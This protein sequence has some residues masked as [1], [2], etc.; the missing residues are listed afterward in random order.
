MVRPVP[1]PHQPP[2]YAAHPVV[3]QSDYRIERPPMHHMAPHHAVPYG[4]AAGLPPQVRPQEPVGE[5]AWERGL[6][7]AK[8][9]MRKATKRK[10]QDIDFE[11]KKMNLSLTQDE[12]EKDNYYTRGSPES[13]S[14]GVRPPVAAAPYEFNAPPVTAKFT[15]PGPAPFEEDAFGRT[16]RYRELPSHRMPQYEDEDPSKRRNR[17]TREVIVQRADEWNDPWMRS[18]SPARE[19]RSARRDRR[20]YS[21]S[22]SYSSSSSSS[23][24]GSSSDSSRSPSP[25]TRRPRYDSHRSKESDRHT[26]HVRKVIRT[27]SPSASPRRVRKVS[28]VVAKKRNV[29]PVPDKRAIEK[30]VSTKRK[31]SSPPR[32]VSTEK[33]RRR[34]SSSGSGSSDSSDSGSESSYSSSSS[35]SSREKSKKSK[36]TEKSSKTAA[37]SKKPAELKKSSSD[38]K[39]SA[40]VI[41]P[42]SAALEKAAASASAAKKSSRREE[43]LKQLRAVE[44]AI[45]R[46]RT[47][48]S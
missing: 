39:P 46:K 1:I 37:S 43:L 45:A 27:R 16:H 32:K 36:A 42:S 19:K 24:S 11:D 18:K 28:P 35:T 10:E 30:A 44:E 33:R 4:A 29:S 25:S 14:Y 2:P 47:K 13:P 48:I 31:K 41:P 9:M 12:L 23:R 26:T 21:N 7:T 3:Y 34:S 38:S 40:Q 15:R 20:S 8:E 22:S 5:S 6:R 17:A